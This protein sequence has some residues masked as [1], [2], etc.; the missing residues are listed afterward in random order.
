MSSKEIFLLT[1][2]KFTI[3]EA[4]I[5]TNTALIYAGLEVNYSNSPLQTGIVISI[6]NAREKFDLDNDSNLLEIMF[7]D[8]ST[9]L[10]WEEDLVQINSET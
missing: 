2:A 3:G 4:V 1:R 6:E 10:I 8:G 7:S 9:D 5:I